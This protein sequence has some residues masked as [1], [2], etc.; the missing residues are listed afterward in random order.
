L[1]SS[2]IGLDPDHSEPS[3]YQSLRA[4][5]SLKTLLVGMGLMYF[6]QFAGYNVIS[7]YAASILKVEEVDR[8]IQIE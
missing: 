3:D 2:Q 4:W 5:D 7:Y 8:A 1:L 6:Y